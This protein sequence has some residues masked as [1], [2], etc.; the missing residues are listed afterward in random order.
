M[1]D[2]IQPDSLYWISSSCGRIELQVPGELILDLA[3]PGSVDDAAEYWVGKID[4]SGVDDAALISDLEQYGCDWEYDDQSA[5]R[6]RF[7]W[8]ASG[9]VFDAEDPD[10]YRVDA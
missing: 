9:Q 8:T 5:N 1:R 7:L 2:S 6:A 3:G 4:W 10:A